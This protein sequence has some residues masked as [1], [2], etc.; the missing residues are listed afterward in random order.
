MSKASRCEGFTLLEVMVALAILAVAA[1]GLIGATGQS[2]RHQSW[3]EEK[4]IAGWI[5]ENRITEIRNQRLWLPVGRSGDAVTMASRQWNVHVD[6]SETSR[7]GLR[8]MLVEVSP[9]NVPSPVPIYSLT[10]FLGKK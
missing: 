10:G 1:S 5:A 3:L 7:P 4:T 8:Q 6:V 2:L 9:T